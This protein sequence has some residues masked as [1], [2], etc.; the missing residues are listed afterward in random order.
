TTDLAA[1]EGML[2]APE[3]PVAGVIAAQPDFVGL[4]EP[5]PEIG[6]LAHAAGAL[7][8]AVVEPVSLAVL[9]PPGAYGADIAAG[10]GQPLGIAPQYGGPYLG[11][12]ASTDALVRQ[13]PG[14]LVGM[15]TDLD[16]RRAFVMTMRAREQDIRRDKAASNIC[17]NQALLALAASVYLA[18]I[19]PHGL[20]DVAAL[21]AVRAAE[22][23]A[24]LAAV[25]AP[26][27]HPG[28]YLNEL[29]V[30]VTHAS[31][32]HRRLLDR[33]V[34]AGLVLA[35]AEPD[36]PSLADGLLVCATA[37]TTADEIDRFAKSLAEVL[38][39]RPPAAVE[40]GAGSARDAMAGAA[41]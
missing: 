26:R 14:R 8:V 29:A 15:T 25:G 37:V 39:G 27:I 34:L 33:G 4:L 11:I 19:G 40:A 24:A 6:R 21:G 23:E 12:L 32:V 9:A 3:R 5:M 10:E 41:R 17:T 16:G 22:L 31:V 30:R 18:T 38:G 36:D 20:R 7:F 28:P 1:L 35:D 2:A 13:I